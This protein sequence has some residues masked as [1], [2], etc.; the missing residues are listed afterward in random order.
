MPSLSIRKFLLRRR[1]RV[2]YGLLPLIFFLQ[3]S[4]HLEIEL[5]LPLYP[6]LLHVPNDALV[7]CLL[8][9]QL[10]L[11]TQK[12]HLIFL[13]RLLAVWRKPIDRVGYT[14]IFL[15]LLLEVHEDDGAG[16]EE[17]RCREGELR[18]A[19]HSAGISR[20]PTIDFAS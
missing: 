3:L 11:L 15:G 5:S 20:E 18:G 17:R 12:L 1:Y 10:Y 16:C 13:R 6:L 14:Y 19:R 2:V 8:E 4:L 7:H 9:R